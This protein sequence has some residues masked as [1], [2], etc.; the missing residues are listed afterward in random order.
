MTKWKED[1]A[2]YDYAKDGYAIYDKLTIGSIKNARINTKYN[3]AIAVSF[4]HGNT[5]DKCAL[6]LKNCYEVAV[7][8]RNLYATA[9]RQ[10][11]PV[12]AKAMAWEIWLHAMPEALDTLIDNKVVRFILGTSLAGQ[13]AKAAIDIAGEHT[14]YA[15]VG[16][17]DKGRK[18]D[19]EFEKAYDVIYGK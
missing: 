13:I 19:D 4:M 3:R 16:I 5:R 17:T 9:Y 2:N 8:A 1:T 6:N 12:S 14:D 15:D 18:W 10:H 11:F 7:K